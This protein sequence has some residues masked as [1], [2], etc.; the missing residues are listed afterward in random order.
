MILRYQKSI[1][2]PKKNPP[3]VNLE[4]KCIVSGIFSA[5]PAAAAMMPVIVNICHGPLAAQSD[6][7][8]V[9]Y[10]AAI[11]AGSSLFMWSATAGFILSG[12]VNGA[13]IEDEEKQ[14]I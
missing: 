5:G 14:K 13:G 10:A 11:C 3:H 6:W 12:K 9:A 8:A 1:I 7:I 4:R 2:L